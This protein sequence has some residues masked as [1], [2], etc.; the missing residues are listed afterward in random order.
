MFGLDLYGIDVVLGPDGPVIVDINDFPSFRQ[1]PDAVSRLAG[2]VL[3]L[4]RTGGAARTGVPAFAPRIPARPQIPH[5]RPHPHPVPGPEA[6]ML[7][8]VPGAAQI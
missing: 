8:A 1:V 3:D 5:G 4:A 6:D 2:A 7:A